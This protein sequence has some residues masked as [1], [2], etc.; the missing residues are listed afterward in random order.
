VEETVSIFW[1]WT[2]VE[3]L[4]RMLGGLGVKGELKK[5]GENG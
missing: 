3:I 2:D 5:G 4:C 1:E